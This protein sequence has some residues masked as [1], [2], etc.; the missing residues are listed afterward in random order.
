MYTFFFK[1]KAGE[2]RSCVGKKKNNASARKICF[3]QFTFMLLIS[4]HFSSIHL[5][6]EGIEAVVV[7]P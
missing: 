6:G 1:K 3:H 4:K 5:G 2:K 7:E